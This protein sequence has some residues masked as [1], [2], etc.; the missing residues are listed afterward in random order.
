MHR[1]QARG[2]SRSFIE[3]DRQSSLRS[4]RA[5]DSDDD[6][7]SRCLRAWGLRGVDYRHRAVGVMQHPGAYRAEQRPSRCAQTSA[8]HDDHLGILGQVSQH[9]DRIALDSALIDG[10][11]PGICGGSFGGILCLAQNLAA[12]LL[13]DLSQ[14]GGVREFLP[15]PRLSLGAD[16]SQRERDPVQD[17][18]PRCPLDSELSFR[19]SVGSDNHSAVRTGHV[20]SSLKNP[21]VVADLF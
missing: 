3:C 15:R 7:R 17:R 8:P 11:R 2:A 1:D 5:V 21:T 16:V 9:R 14:F 18:L 19:R 20:D 10:E 6:R 13:G 4:W 12:S